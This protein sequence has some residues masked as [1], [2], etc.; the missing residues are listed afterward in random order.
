MT[1]EYKQQIINYFER[2]TAYDAEGNSHPQQARLLLDYVT[3]ESGQTVLDIATGT[4]LVAIPVAQKVAPAGFV[5]GVDISPGMLA[6][7]RSKIVA[8]GIDNLELI[9][10]DIESV[11]FEFERFNTIYCC[12]ALVY[13][14]DIL[15]IIRKCHSW[16]KLGGCFAF[17]TPYKTLSL[18]DVKVDVCKKLFNIDLPH[19]IRPLWTLEKCRNL[20]EKAGF[21]N[22]EIEQNQYYKL[23]IERNYGSTRIE[24]EFYPRGNPLVD[25]SA[26]QKDLLQTEYKKAVEQII[27]QRG[28]WVENY[29]LFVKAYK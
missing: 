11:E 26:E 2:R 19:I 13:I 5:I 4:G 27:A 25:L 8:K 20:L 24:N 15:G 21:Q 22:I 10:A 23:E 3:V 29:N 14:S 9:E 17:T 18:A 28:K 12:S 16:L 6:Q 7:A 1:D